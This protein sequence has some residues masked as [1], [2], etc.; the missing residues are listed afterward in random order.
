MNY[1]NS[2]GILAFAYLA[3]FFE[4]WFDGFR[5]LM[6]AQFDLLPALMVYAALTVNLG[7]LS[8]AALTGGLLFDALSA[9]PLGVTP[10]PLFLVGFVIYGKRELILRTQAYAQLVLGLAASAIVPVMTVLLLQAIGEKP[11]IGWVSLTQWLVLTL[12]GG[13]ATPMLFWMFDRLNGALSYR[14]RVETPFRP[15]REIKRGRI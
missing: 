15:D 7:M 1:V 13:V 4:A 11:L 6:G 5:N 9:N 14:P 12:T 8:L 2:I 3:V 10:L